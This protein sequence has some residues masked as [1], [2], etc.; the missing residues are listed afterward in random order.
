MAVNDSL[1][2]S[3]D[4]SCPDSTLAPGASETCT[5]SYTVTQADV[6]NGSVTNTA[7]AS[8]TA[9]DPHDGH[10]ELVLGDGR[11]LR[12]HLV[13]QP[14]Q[15][16]RLDELQRSRTGPD[17]SYKVTNTGTETLSDVAVSDSLI[18]YVDCRGLHARSWSVGDLH[19]QLHDDPGGR[20]QRVGDQLGHRQRQGTVGDG[21]GPVTSNTSSVTVDY[22]G[23]LITTTSPLPDGDH[24][25]PL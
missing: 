5:A 16:E 1:I 2:P 17:Y 3:A 19:G 20:G 10:V 7:T 9:L 12:C 22:S 4:V 23:I 14:D 15:V 8:G 11:R 18:S 6:D 25:H 24:R 21:G 13:P